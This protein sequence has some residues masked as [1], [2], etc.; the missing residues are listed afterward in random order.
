MTER[1]IRVLIADDHPVFREGLKALLAIQPGFEVV[2]EAA[3]G[4]EAT[5]LVLEQRPDLLLLDFAM[6][7]HP[8][9]EALRKLAAADLPLR[10]IV[11]TAAIERQQI[12]EA[13]RLGARGVVLKQA[14]T[15]LLLKSIRAVMAGEYWI[16]RESVADLIA[17]LRSPQPSRLA[18]A[19]KKRYGLTPRELEIVAAVVGG[20]TNRDIGTKLVI[21]EDTVK[22]HLTNIFDKTGVS[23][24]LELALFAIHKGLVA[25][26]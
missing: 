2:G 11:L 14:A 15:E 20:D 1:P 16:G 26:D 17:Y 13:I 18:E 8:G 24:R 10:T 4:A 3:D 23:T 6:P 5:R 19:E 25:Q 7:R 9:M 21:S 22:R 12:V